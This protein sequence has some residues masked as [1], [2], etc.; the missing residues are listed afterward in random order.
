MRLELL[1][2]AQL[3]LLGKRQRAGSLK[4]GDCP[5]PPAC[6]VSTGGALNDRGTPRGL[7]ATGECN[8]GAPRWPIGQF[9]PSAGA[10]SRYAPVCPARRRAAPPRGH[11]DL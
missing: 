4:K 6:Q 7:G 8:I 3:L 2:D 5:A 9:R 10:A 1:D 11:A